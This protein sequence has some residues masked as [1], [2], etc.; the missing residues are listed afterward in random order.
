MFYVACEM[1]DKP[2]LKSKPCAVGKKNLF[3]YKN[4]TK[5][6]IILFFLDKKKENFIFILF[7]DLKND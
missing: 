4:L 6:F 3:Y 2:E 5:R 7:G 1:R